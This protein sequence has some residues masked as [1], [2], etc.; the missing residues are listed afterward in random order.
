M[1]LLRTLPLLLL[2]FSAFGSQHSTLTLG[3]DNDGVYG[4]DQDY[5]SGIFL[6]YTSPAITPTR[7]TRPL[8]L[9]AWGAA[10]LDKWE[11]SIGHKMWTP[12]DITL[13]TPQP[14]E[15]P[16]AG[17]LHTEF[18]YISLHPQQA[19]RFNLTI[20]TTG[21][22]A[23]SED[24]QKIVHSI[25]KS[26]DP[27]GWAYQV[28]DKVVGSVGYLSHFNLIRR[29]F[30]L[31]TD[32]EISNISELNIGNYRSDAA[33]GFMVRWGQDL[34][35]NFGS[36]QISVEN[37][38]KAGMIGASDYG[39][40]LF[41]GIEGRYRFNDITLEGSRPLND[42]DHPANYYE[43]TLQPWQATAVVG[44]AWYSRHFGFTFTTTATTSEF[45]QDQ[46][47]VHGTG[48]ASFYAFF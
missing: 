16:Y 11:V 41:G 38:F 27:N 34:A 47:S 8:S 5:T 26:D 6:S 30:T 44:A 17:F 7:W 45:K 19:Q 9:S 37:P 4:V 36:A 29:R 22:D 23:L 3:V 10:S 20:G 43:V 40:F 18:N 31:S 32:I 48:A 39:W 21:E 33:T 13:E 1:N 28:E 25:T 12:S 46:N 35:D 15:R 42:L 24:A 14:N 2:S